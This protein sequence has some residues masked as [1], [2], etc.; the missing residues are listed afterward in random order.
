MQDYVLEIK[1]LNKDFPGVRAVNDVSFGIKRNTV[2][3]LV[4]ENGAGKSTLIKILTGAYSKT[5]G[6]LLLNGQDYYPHN[7]R[8]A[9]QKG[10]STVFQELNIVDQLTVEENLTLGVEDTRLGFLIKTDKIKKII[11][12]LNS[13]EPS[14]NPKLPVS[15]LSVAQKQIV[16]IAKAVAAESDIIIMD[17]PTAAI[18]ES[19]IKRLFEIIKSLRDENVTVIYISHRLD[20]I[21]ELGDYV[22]IMRDGKH[23]DT[24]PLAEINRSELIKMMIG[25]TI[26]E[27]YI[28]KE[29]Q[30]EQ[31]LLEVNNINTDKLSNI[32]FTIKTGE[33]VGFYGHVGAGK[34][35]LARAIFGADSYEGDILFKGKKLNN[36]PHKSIEA[37]ITLIPE[38]RRT[39]GL[40]TILTI[41][42]N[43]PV[44][45]MKK[46]SRVG[47]V[48]NSEE[49]KVALEYIDKLNIVTNTMEKQTSKLSGGNQQK[50]VFSK[51]LFA[52]S[53]LLILDEPTRGIDVGAKSEIYNIIRQLAKD[54]KSI[55]IFS[56]ELPE[57]IN[58]CDRIFL[59]YDGHMK[60]EIENTGNI[61]SE[62]IIHIATGGETV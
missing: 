12:V 11:S 33:I 38:E 44:M 62:E 31:V 14:I 23:I 32:S 35:E 45:N 4:G 17:E 54:G 29:L 59:M 34:T 5:S 40:F 3:C 20:E 21:F 58:I 13:L 48:N 55:M 52:D 10:I 51:C 2:H 61:N 19:E 15:R 25:K 30:T 18:S 57:V 49:K 42:N 8:E 47:F 22:T 26:F 24:K 46:I 16:E 28:P 50:V 6:T 9:K 7:I 56:S 53:D 1:N 36:S 39:Q 60:A 43:I 37:G 41:R 27:T